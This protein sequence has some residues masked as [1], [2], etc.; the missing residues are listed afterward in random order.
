MATP[1]SSRP[2]SERLSRSLFFFSLFCLAIAYGMYAWEHNWFPANAVRI[3]L[4]QWREISVDEDE[5]LVDDSRVS[6]LPPVAVGGAAPQAGLTLIT[7]KDKI[8][9]AA[10]IDESGEVVQHWD[11]DWHSLWPDASHLPEKVIPKRQPGTHIHGAVVLDNGDLVFNF[12]HLGMLRLDPCGE[13]VWRLPYRTHHSIHRDAE[14]ML[15]ASGQ[16]DHSEDSD[17]FHNYSAPFIEP[18]IIKVSPDGEILLEKS[19]MELLQDNGMQGLLYMQGMKSLKTETGG[20]TLHLNDVETFDLVGE[21]GTFARGDVMISLRNVNAV[22]IFDRQWQ[23]K[24]SWIGPFVRQ[25]DPDFLDADRVSVYDNNFIG[26]PEEERSSRILVRDFARGID[27]LRF[28]GSAA[29]PFYSYI[30]GKH[31]WLEN[32]NLLITESTAGRA[33]ELTPTGDIAWQHHHVMANGK[34]GLLEEAQRLPASFTAELFLERRSA[35][36]D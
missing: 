25:H 7:A 16:R 10:V 9:K 30:M 13:V 6:P 14:G 20:D 29:A 15:W 33:F 28:E 8:L 31:Q 18:T 1:D 11:I 3:S 5:Q 36:G 19:V 2:V 34:T 22:L 17:R 23:L 35:C 32:G 4:E 12:E 21:N 27:S 26:A 24:Y